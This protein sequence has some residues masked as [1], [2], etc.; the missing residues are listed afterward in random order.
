MTQNIRSSTGIQSSTNLILTSKLHPH[1]GTQ[2]SGQ[3]LY[4]MT[5]PSYLPG[6]KATP[7]N[8]ID[9]IFVLANDNLVPRRKYRN[10]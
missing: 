5:T 10:I 4:D 1:T 8:G 6:L 2:S 9:K 3:F 7:P